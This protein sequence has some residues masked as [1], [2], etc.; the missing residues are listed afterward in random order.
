[1]PQVSF[2][3]GV[4]YDALQKEN[5]KVKPA[6]ADYKVQPGLTNVV[7]R[8]IYGALLEPQLKDLIAKNGFAVT[9][10]NYIQMFQIYEN[11]Q[12][13]RPRLPAFIT[14]DSMLHTYHIF[15]DY[16]LRKVESDKL[17]KAAVDLTH[18]MLGAA[19]DDLKAASTPELKDAAR[20]NVAYFAVARKLL[21]GAT[22]P[23][24]G[25]DM[26]NADLKLIDEHAGRAISS[27]M[28]CKVEFSQ[29]I[30][31]G[32]Y[33][34]SEKL[35]KYFRGMMWYGLTPF[36][37]PQGNI[38]SMPTRQALMITRFLD[39]GTNGAKAAFGLWD[40]IYEPTVFYVGSADDYT[41]RQYA[42]LMHKVYGAKPDIG[43]FADKG[44]LATFIGEVR[45]LPGPGIENYASADGKTADPLYPVGRQFRFMGQRFIPDSRILQELTNPKVNGRNFPKGLDVFAAMGS[46]RALDILNKSDDLPAVPGWTKQMTKMRREMR[47]TALATWQSNLY[48]GWLWSLQPI[49]APLP[50]GYP[51][52][53]RTDAWLDKS[54][55]TALGSWTE[56]RHDTILYAKQSVAECGG[57]G[58]E[59]PIT[60]NYVEP[61]LEFWTRLKW[62]N[63]YTETGLSSRHLIDAPLK[64]KFDQLSDWIDFCRKITVKELTNA[65]VTDD[66]YTQMDTYGADLEQMMLEFAEGD[67]I[68]DTDKDQALVA[69]VHTS[70]DMCL[71]EG[72]GRVAAIYIVVPIQGK[73]Y[74]TRGAVYTQ[75]EF[76]W[77]K[78]DRLTD[79][80][81]QKLLNSHQE[82]GFADWTKTFLVPTKKKLAPEF[83]NF[84]G[85]C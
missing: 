29:F 54:L 82:P 60:K 14:T 2:A 70:S 37:I 46:E 69:D 5:A 28:G 52:A 20:R 21:T 50:V 7:N 79:E 23:P 67:I 13:E 31:R 74:L 19:Q 36:A 57:A 76:E 1:M 34:R 11:N 15:Y 51:S 49:T 61:N 64:A 80:K 8:K 68:S 73:L 33:T 65:R 4:D 16:T 63:A 47:E 75:Y 83:D 38:G 77:P 27:V 85:G 32:H 59:I 81:W 40:K 72:T 35:K 25:R 6:I 56:L 55:F 58:E 24:E 84:F 9:P 66:E 62:L 71:E 10:T 48:Y 44:K 30:P 39:S 26:A 45:K 42:K 18:I 43:A 78:S 17:Y 22:P 41:V 12:Y 53:M 3:S